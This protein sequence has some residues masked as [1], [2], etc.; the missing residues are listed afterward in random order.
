MLQVYVQFIL[1]RVGK[2]AR[3]DEEQAAEHANA[4]QWNVEH[5]QRLPSQRRVE[6]Y[7]TMLLSL[8]TATLCWS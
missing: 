2:L 8:G 3:D 5:H 1:D 4:E 7:R 6:A